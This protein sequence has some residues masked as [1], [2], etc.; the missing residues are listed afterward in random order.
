MFKHMDKI[1]IS[2]FAK[3]KCLSLPM[4]TMRKANNM[5]WDKTD[6]SFLFVFVIYPPTASDILSN[7]SLPV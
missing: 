7:K 5:K 4:V 6:L 3:K 2:S 1:I